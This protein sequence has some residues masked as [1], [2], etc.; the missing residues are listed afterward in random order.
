MA[1]GQGPEQRGTLVAQRPYRTLQVRL[2]GVAMDAGG[3]GSC[4]RALSDP[5]SQLG[6]EEAP[7]S[8][9]SEGDLRSPS[10]LSL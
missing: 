1:P 10:S 7:G 2:P 6:Q 8:W 9:D 4:Y 5:L 3:S